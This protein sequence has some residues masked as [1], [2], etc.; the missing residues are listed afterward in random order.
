MQP[1]KKKKKKKKQDWLHDT[2]RQT[3]STLSND[4]PSLDHKGKPNSMEI[5]LSLQNM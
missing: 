3:A 5:L 4:G 2:C 1:R